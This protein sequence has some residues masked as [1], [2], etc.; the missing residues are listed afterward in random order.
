MPIAEV[1]HQKA[2]AAV[3]DNVNTPVSMADL[4]VVAQ[5]AW[6][7]PSEARPFREAAASF[8]VSFDDAFAQVATGNQSAYKSF[9]LLPP[10]SAKS[11]GTICCDA[12]VL[13]A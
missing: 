1:L 7:G 3:R 11:D 6:S 9:R 13:Y 5:H 4:S 12:A 2:N 10:E 8:I